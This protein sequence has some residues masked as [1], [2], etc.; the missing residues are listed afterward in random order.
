M[1]NLFKKILIPYIFNDKKIYLS[2][3]SL[4][5]FTIFYALC[6]NDEFHGWVDTEEIKPNIE[7]NFIK[8]I[9]KKYSKTNKYLTE[10]EFRNIPIIDKDGKFYFVS[11]YDKEYKKKENL[12][13]KNILFRIYSSDG[14]L[15]FNK[16]NQMPILL[17]LMD[18]YI[19]PHKILYP[20]VR[21]KKS[22]AVNSLFDR[23]YFSIIVQSNLGLGDIFPAS[24]R[25]RVIMIIQVIISYIIII[26]PYGSL[27]GLS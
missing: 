8:N 14:R 3:I 27:I 1:I 17:N 18:G 23:F 15:Y 9:F 26:V 25:V 6:N 22:K 13:S 12:V 21:Y 4:I 16:F 24:K 11:D 7:Q 5:A 10:K 20:S 2:F 19:K